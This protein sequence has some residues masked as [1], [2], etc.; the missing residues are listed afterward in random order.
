MDETTLQLEC[1]RAEVDIMAAVLRV[2][3]D[4]YSEYLDRFLDMQENDPEGYPEGFPELLASREAF[5]FL[6]K[7]IRNQLEIEAAV[8][9]SA[10]ATRH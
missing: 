4:K 1:K 3:S 5:F 2:A 8:L 10:K 9:Q 7:A 6:L